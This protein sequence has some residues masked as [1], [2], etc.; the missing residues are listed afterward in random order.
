[1]DQYIFLRSERRDSRQIRIHKR[2]PKKILY[3]KII[4]T[5]LAHNFRNP[6]FKTDLLSGSNLQLV[7]AINLWVESM[8]WFWL[9]AAPRLYKINRRL[10]NFSRYRSSIS[11]WSPWRIQ[12]D[13]CSPDLWRQD[14]G[15]FKARLIADGHRRM[16]HSNPYILVL[17]RSE[18]SASLY[19]SRN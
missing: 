4:S 3:I 17:F 7:V 16:R 11:Y 15:R 6:T 9:I 1:M 5:W 18:A 14:D 10:W 8:L 2:E 12:G 19:S 13:T